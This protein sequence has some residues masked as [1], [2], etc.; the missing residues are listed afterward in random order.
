M[1]TLIICGTP[2]C[3]LD[4]VYQKFQQAGLAAP[5]SAANGSIRT[6][7]DWHHRLFA[8]R[9]WPM[10]AVQPGKSWE[11]AAGDIF[12]ANWEQP[13]WGWADA[14]S[15]WLLDFWLQFDAQIRFVLVHTPAVDALV[16]ATQQSEQSADEMPFDAQKVLDSW[17]AHQEQML[18]FSL[19]HRERCMWVTRCASDVV[20]LGEQSESL[21]ELPWA[22]PLQRPVTL[23]R[24]PG[25]VD[26]TARLLHALAVQVVQ[27]HGRAAVLQQEVWASLPVV[28]AA[29]A[30]KEHVQDA[31]LE[32]AGAPVSPLQ[33][34]GIQDAALLLN[35]V[36][37]V[38]VLHMRA[39]H[40]QAQGMA[41]QAVQLSQ[42]KAELQ[43]LLEAQVQ[44]SREATSES[45][46][47]LLQLH[48][49]QEELESA[50]LQHQQVLAK[51][52][53]EAQDRLVA[54]KAQAELQAALKAENSVN[55]QLTQ[56]RDALSKEKTELHQRLEAEARA[57]Q[58]A[59][60]EGELLLLQLHQ[61]Q[62]ELESYFLQHQQAQ[63][64]CAG[65]QARLLRWAQR[66]PDHCEWESVAFLPQM[67][68]GC[69][70]V[71]L[72]QVQ[73]GARVLEQLHVK[74]H[75][76]KK[77]LQLVVVRG[78]GA[79]SPL[80]RW[81]SGGRGAATEVLLDPAALPGSAEAAQLRGLAPA[82]LQL[83]KAVCKGL[84]SHLQDGAADGVPEAKLWAKQ[85][86]AMAEALGA[87]PPSLR[88]DAVSLRHEQVNPDYEHL[89]LRL[90]N[91]QYGERRWPVFEFRLSAN[92][93]RKAKWTHLPKL[94]FPLPEQ[95]GPKQFENW[96]E[97]SEDDQGPKFELRFDM[98]APAMDIQCWNALSELDQKQAWELVRSLPAMLQELEQA[99]ARIHR[100]WDDWQL[101][102]TGIEQTLM[103]CLN[104][105]S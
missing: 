24:E 101:L 75:H 71:L 29:A 23:R 41:H 33:F 15:T 52:E 11:Q 9:P 6:F 53:T 69:Q 73:Q 39:L 83:L 45:E 82:D 43:Q 94:E 10:E 104:V 38:A 48:Q 57:R 74:L 98:K 81:P 72:T 77:Q 5:V 86:L 36:R 3:D 85:W 64:Q 60:E 7:E 16:A 20:Q 50:F 62:E 22:L 12:L 44:A 95:G 42:E 27:Q 49:V 67:Q 1:H 34:S 35:Q 68:V 87:L 59:T 103:A 13:V 58:D 18:Q 32:P 26:A 88:F 89:W 28:F 47:L 91:T 37:E 80:L 100:S 102:A 30:I 70:E 90:S 61:V 105:K 2:W 4:A 54:Q 65:L 51:L 8:H 17:C 66:Y 19:R 97:E 40:E 93:V 56:Q 25:P 84:A 21:A 76:H 96:F 55:A 31:T 92:N 99:G 79:E 63:A 14:R 78:D 46:L